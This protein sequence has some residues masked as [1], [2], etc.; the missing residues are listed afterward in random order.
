MIRKVKLEDAP[1]IVKK[2]KL[3]EVPKEILTESLISS[4]IGFTILRLKT[5]KKADNKELNI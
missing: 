1:E 4:L 3:I 5:N 2:M